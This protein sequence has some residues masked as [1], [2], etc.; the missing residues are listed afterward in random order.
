MDRFTLFFGPPILTLRLRIHAALCAQLTA[1]LL[2]ISGLVALDAHAQIY[3]YEGPDGTLIFSTKPR[4]DLTPS[5]VH[6]G[7]A[8]EESPTPGR[9]RPSRPNPNPDSSHNAFDASIQEAANAYSIPFA[10]IKA[11]IRA[12]SSFNPHAVSHAGA[13]GLM[14]L[15]PATAD[16]LNCADPFDPRSNILAGTQYLRILLDRYNGDVN[17]A[18][19][20][21]NAGSGAVARAGG[22]PF[23]A[24]R[25]YI[26]RVYSFYVEYLEAPSSRGR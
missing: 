21:Y 3:Q 19:A 23:E 11:V 17:L 4:P 18:L 25:R 16:S 20:T 15:M 7:R 6:G 22:I 2:A 5:R 12:E 10:M 13:M 1:A 24:T 8:Q 14:Q 26:E 9:E